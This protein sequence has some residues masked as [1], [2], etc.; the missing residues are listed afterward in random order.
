MSRLAF[1]ISGFMPLLSLP[2][3]ATISLV[4]KASTWLL[5]LRLVF[6]L[7]SRMLV[8]QYLKGIPLGNFQPTHALTR[9]H[10]DDEQ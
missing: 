2:P 10:N 9:T 3:S 4:L 7:P 5:Y 6:R 1:P 8:S